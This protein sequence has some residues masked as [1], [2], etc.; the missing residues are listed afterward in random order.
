MRC[1]DV[2]TKDPAFVHTNDEVAAANRLMRRRNIGF[3]PVCDESGA[4]VGFVTE[5]HLTRVVIEQDIG[6]SA[7]VESVMGRDVCI[8]SPDDDVDIA[9][10]AIETHPGRCAVCVGPAREPIGVIGVSDLARARA[11]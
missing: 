1:A 8:C 4:V 7:P 6:P 2:M 9:K 5:Q 3:L 11:H 10:R